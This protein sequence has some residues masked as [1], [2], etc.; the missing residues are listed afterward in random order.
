MHII[1][2]PTLPKN[3]PLYK[4][5]TPLKLRPDNL[6]KSIFFKI[7]RNTFEYSDYF[8]K[9]KRETKFSYGKENPD[10]I[11][12]IIAWENM[13]TGLFYRVLNNLRHIAYAI[14]HKYIPV[15]DMQNFNNQ[16]LDNGAL[17][18]ENSWEY[19]FEQPM[20]YTLND[21]SQSKNILVSYNSHLIPRSIKYSRMDI[22][23]AISNDEEKLSYFRN[24]FNLYIRPNTAT[25]KYLIFDYNK[26][27][28]DKERVLGVLCR[29][30]DYVIKRPKN[31]PIQPDP[32]DV[33]KKA[34]LVM[35]ERSCSYL[36]LATEDE[37]IYNL[38]KIYFGDRLLVN[39]QNRFDPSDL[40]DVQDLS[41]IHHERDR[42]KYRLGLE[43]YSSINL[44]S[45][46]TC[47]IG[48]KTGGTI[49]VY[50]M[51]KGFE[52]DYVWDLGSY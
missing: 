37:N 42:D 22:G 38:F 41:Q 27:F 44:L 52:Y 12:Y 15:I 36:Y 35:R 28:R 9:N 21:I 47:F 24:L 51:T 17:G 8:N 2:Q 48:G 31:H 29:G 46:C 7:K 30:T 13:N 16:Y 6:V 14:E 20:G 49:G 10:K 32:E 43:Y 25:E 50:C 23:M 1:K 11:F 45:K 39:S 40:K 18:K 34:E 5:L 4:R 33:I 3:K 26:I 19:Y